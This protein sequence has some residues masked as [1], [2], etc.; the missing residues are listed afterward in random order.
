MPIAAASKID[1]L[2]Y[3]VSQG[4]RGRGS[5]Q[6]SSGNSCER[7]DATWYLVFAP[8]ALKHARNFPS[9]ISATLIEERRARRRARR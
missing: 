6:A 8:L 7:N 1:M 4:F 3:S 2:R 9:L 5:L